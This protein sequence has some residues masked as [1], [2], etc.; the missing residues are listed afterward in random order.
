[1]M[2]IFDNWINILLI[3][4]FLMILIFF[5]IGFSIGYYYSDKSC[6]KD[7]FSYGLK[8]IDSLNH[9]TMN[10]T[11]S[12]FSISGEATPFSFDEKGIKK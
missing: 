6:I 1:M 11:C 2:K 12:C 4:I 8:K 9:R 7:P 3:I 10:F 5:L